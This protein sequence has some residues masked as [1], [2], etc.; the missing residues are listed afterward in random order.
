[1]YLDCIYIL[2]LERMKNRYFEVLERL[3]ALGINTSNT[4]IVRWRGIDGSEVLP[5]SKEIYGTD[6]FDIKK[7]FVEKLNTTLQKHNYISKKT[8]RPFRPGQIAYYYSFIR[9]IRDAKEKGY[10]KILFLEDD[11]FF[12]DGFREKLEDI[13]NLKDDVLFIGTSH[14]FWNRKAKTE[15]TNW[16]CP[17]RRINKIQVDYP[18][19]CLNENTE[20]NNAFLGTFGCIINNSAY[21]KLLELSTP[22]RYPLDV[23]LG[24]LYREH[25]LSAAFFKKPLVYVDYNGISHTGSLNTNGTKNKVVI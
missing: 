9:M 5:F 6:D 14:G 7:E 3:E 8:D 20:L 25:R 18:L 12:V 1:M 16:I 4:N 13:N 19:G 2:N 17:E 11:V 22:M 21:D 23:Y 10:N 24:K 15:K